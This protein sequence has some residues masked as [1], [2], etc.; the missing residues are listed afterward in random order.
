MKDSKEIAG[1]INQ[2]F[3]HLTNLNARYSALENALFHVV[4]K[5]DPELFSELFTMFVDDYESSIQEQMD[6][7]NQLLMESDD[8]SALIRNKFNFLCSI[9]NL[10][11]IEAYKNSQKNS[12]SE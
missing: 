3:I 11:Q 5:K 10:K 9:Q 2:L 6:N 12:Q 4:Q 7:L 1:Y 8:P